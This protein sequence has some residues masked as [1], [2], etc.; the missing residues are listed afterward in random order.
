[1]LYVQYKIF[2]R[3]R[4][5]LDTDRAAEDAIR[6]VFEALDM[7]LTAEESAALAETLPLEIREHLAANRWRHRFDLAQFREWIAGIEGVDP[8]T[9]QQH[10][11][12][13]LSVL[14]EYLP[15]P[16]LLI[17]L[18]GL[19]GEIRGLFNWMKKAA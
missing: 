13:V 19:P 1:M 14:A 10:A 11:A 6:A 17:V 2:V 18:D 8:E 16:A 5:G 7:M 9:A 3:E 12:A 15:S 4:A